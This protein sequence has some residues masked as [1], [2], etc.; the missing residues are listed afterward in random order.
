MYQVKIISNLI[1]ISF[2]KYKKKSKLKILSCRNPSDKTSGEKSL[3]CSKLK[4]L[5]LEKEEGPGI[6]ES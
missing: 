1:D 5:V 6:G 4:E 3:T 2:K